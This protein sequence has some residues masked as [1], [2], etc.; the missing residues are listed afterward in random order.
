MGCASAGG[1]TS[2]PAEDGRILTWLPVE[3]LQ[4]TMSMRY[5]AWAIGSAWELQQKS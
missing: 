4:K 1:G 2:G 3:E 5:R